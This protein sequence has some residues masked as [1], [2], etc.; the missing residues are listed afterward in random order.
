MWT[1]PDIR[2]CYKLRLT[3]IVCYYYRDEQTE[4]WNRLDI[5]ESDHCTCGDM[6]YILLGIISSWDRNEYSS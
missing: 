3:K 2:F 1:L 5:P 6:K 4:Q